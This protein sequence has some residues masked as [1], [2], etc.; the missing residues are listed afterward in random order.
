MQTARD[1]M[2]KNVVVVSSDTPLLKAANIL[3]EKKFN[4]L[5]VVDRDRKVIGIITEYDLIIK[6]TA[7]HLPT[8]MKIFQELQLYKKG[9]EPLREDLK[10]I[11]QL[12]VSDIM[13]NDPLVV[14]EDTDIIKISELFSQ[15]H[16]V[17]PI[18]V[19]NSQNVLVG[20]IS[21]HDLLKFFGD[22][23][24]ENP[25]GNIEGIVDKFL[26]NYNNKFVLV[27]KNRTRLWLL[28][29]ILFSIVGFLIAWFLIL[30]LTN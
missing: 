11:F 9:S 28:A 7:I 29:S 1:L 6:G 10:K 13:N 26:N 4:G 22:P 23:E 17:N 27:E 20:I 19:I 5:P 14:A 24:I 2:T 21:R 8:F 30:R 25:G 16:K 15:H 18:P 3:I 12:K